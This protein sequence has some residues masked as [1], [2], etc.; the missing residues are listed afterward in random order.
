MPDNPSDVD[1]I[2]IDDL[3]VDDAADVDNPQA[4]SP[5]QMPLPQAQ[6]PQ[7]TGAPKKYAVP[8]APTALADAAPAPETAAITQRNQ[9]AKQRRS[10]VIPRQR[11]RRG[12]ESTMAAAM[13]ILLILLAT[14]M[15]L[16]F[17][18][19]SPEPLSETA[20]P[21]T[22]DVPSAPVLKSAPAP[23]SLPPPVTVPAPVASAP[24][25]DL[26]TS[27]GD[28]LAVWQ[29]AWEGSAGT[30]GNLAN[31]LNCYAPDFTHAGMD[32]ATWAADKGFKNRRKDWIR[33]RLS[34][35]RITPP[36]VGD[37]VSVTFAQNYASSN[38]SEAS[39][40]TLLLKRSGPSWQII[41]I[42]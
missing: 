40:K 22:F 12:N 13:G 20:A 42:Q 28:F 37:T 27:V 3:L 11:I 10:A 16:Y 41:G 8:Q 21:K 4:R 18:P 25:A 14:G 15:Y 32:K 26:E 30:D 24:T 29:A 17:S 36:E 23:A 33:V 1:F 7:T 6:S 9:N 39:E 35:I 2:H 34:D 19:Q 31:Y 38:Y 5:V